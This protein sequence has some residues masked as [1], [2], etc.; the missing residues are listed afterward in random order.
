MANGM[1]V[2]GYFTFPLEADTRYKSMDKEVGI[3]I[4][5]QG[6]PACCGRAAQIHAANLDIILVSGRGVLN[7]PSENTGSHSAQ[8]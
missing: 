3:C 4:Q 2:G 8:P 7:L 1:R 5:I 6:P